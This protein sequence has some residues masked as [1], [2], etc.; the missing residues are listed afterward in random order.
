MVGESL[1]L[2]LSA[3]VHG[4]NAEDTLV[5]QRR[6]EGYKAFQ[7]KLCIA[8]PYNENLSCMHQ[9]YG[10]PQEE[11]LGEGCVARARCAGPMVHVPPTLVMLMNYGQFA[12]AIVRYAINRG[13]V[14]IDPDHLMEWL[15]GAGYLMIHKERLGRFW[16]RNFARD[17]S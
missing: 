14:M 16:G 3:F 8:W 7:R 13:F 5:Q 10:H 17:Q 9:G 6:V 4:F 11:S 2:P 1:H 12:E 15:G